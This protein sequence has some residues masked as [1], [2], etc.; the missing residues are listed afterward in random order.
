MSSKYNPVHLKL[1]EAQLVAYNN[2]DLDKFLEC[3]HDE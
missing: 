2:R 1:V 3:F